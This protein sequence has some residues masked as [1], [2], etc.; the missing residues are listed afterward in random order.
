MGRIALALLAWLIVAGHTSISFLATQP[1]AEVASAVVIA[2][3]SRV[4]AWAPLRFLGGISYG[5]YL[6]HIP[7]LWLLA[8]SSLLGIYILFAASLVAGWLSHVLVERWF[9]VRKPEIHQVA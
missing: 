7:L 4:L 8:P 5:I 1:M 6:W 9:L 2:H 3:P